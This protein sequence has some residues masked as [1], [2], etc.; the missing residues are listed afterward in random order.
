MADVTQAGSRERVALDLMNRI[1]TTEYD[2][3]YSARPENPREYLLKLYEQCYN[4]VNG[5]DA[6]LAIKLYPAPKQS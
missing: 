2:P 4:V 5:G 1:F 3:G 6:E